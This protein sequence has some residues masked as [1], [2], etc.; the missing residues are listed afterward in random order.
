MVA[1]TSAVLTNEVLTNDMPVRAGLTLGDRLEAA[2]CRNFVGRTQEVSLFRAALAGEPGVPAVL[3]MHGPAGVGKTTLLRRFAAEARMAGRPVVWVDGRAVM[4]S[5]SPEHCAGALG[6][7]PM[8]QSGQMFQVSRVFQRGAARAL[9]QA[10]AV[11]L[12]DSFEDCRGLETWVREEFLPLLPAGA[13]TVLAGRL[14]PEPQWRTDL[15]WHEATTTMPLGG[16]TPAQTAAFLDRHRIAP[17]LREPLACFTGGHPLALR[18]AAEAV[19][20]VGTIEAAAPAGMPWTPPRAVVETLLSRLVGEVPSPVHR[21]ALEICAH[22]LETTEE[23]L[24]VLLPDDA[25]QLFAWLRRLPFVEPG[26]HGLVPH[27]VVRNVVDSDLRWR[28]LVGYRAMHHAIRAHVVE[29]ARAATGPAVQP[30]VAALAHVQRGGVPPRGLPCGRWDDGLREE[31]FR[32]QD[33]H[34]RAELL[35]LAAQAEGKE[36]AAAVDFWLDRQP[37]AFHV[38]RDA[39]TGEAAGFVAWLRLTE[40]PA[41]AAAVDPVVAAAW[42]HGRTVAP[43]RAGEHL[44]VARFLVHPTAHQRPAPGMDLALRRIMAGWLH[45]DRLAWSYCVFADAR[46]WAPL[47]AYADHAPIAAEPVLGGRAHGLFAHDWR[48][49]PVEA[50][51]D[52]QEDPQLRAARAGTAE[53]TVLSRADFATAVRD[54]LRL[55][56]QRDRFAGNPLLRTRLVA[57]GGGD[58]PVHILRGL[59]RRVVATL[60]EDP[61]SVDSHRALTTTFLDGT[62][63][64]EAAARRLGLSF[65]TYRRHLARGI[66]RVCAMLWEREVGG[67]SPLWPDPA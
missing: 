58:D 29:R 55:W 36:S 10:R 54:A 12:V 3:L 56:H 63:T 42:E 61:R 13:L 51:L 26:R 2:R 65:S 64:Q 59:L 25:A 62:P 60:G 37:E 22:A 30:A 17:E 14:P 23:L 5:S 7:S 6:A 44:A 39:R 52:R 11:L 19:E 21:R 38:H 40:L 57:H 49:V 53:L 18:L 34:A 41:R 31:E 50:W 28:D 8:P 1:L 43:L 67:R 45:A 24:R 32:P 33:L 4:S 48:A 47:M 20:A 27:V 16:L 46:F 35:R 66:E 9:R 15:G